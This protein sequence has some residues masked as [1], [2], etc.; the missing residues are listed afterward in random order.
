MRFP[1][2]ENRINPEKERM[3]FPL[4]EKKRNLREKKGSRS[5]IYFYML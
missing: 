3:R 2:K 4:K 5:K 1:L